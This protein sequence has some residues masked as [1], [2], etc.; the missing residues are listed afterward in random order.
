M[1]LRYALLIQPKLQNEVHHAPTT[2]IHA[3][4]PVSPARG[5]SFGATGQQRQRSDSEMERL[6]MGVRRLGF[7]QVGG[8]KPA[9]SQKKNAGGFGSVGPVKAAAEGRHLQYVFSGQA[10]PGTDDDEKYARSKFGSQKAISSDEFFGK[11]AFDPN[12]QTSP[13]TRPSYLPSASLRRPPY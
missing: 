7:G 6:G 1:Q 2:T 9:P 12:A 13:L 4:T 5:G 3:P 11:G 10:N 8:N